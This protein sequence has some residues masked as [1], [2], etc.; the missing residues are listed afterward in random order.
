M[1]QQTQLNKIEWQEVE[2]RDI[3]TFEEKT[4]IK[5]G[6]GLDEGRYKFFTSSDLQ[7]RFI[8]KFNF[9]GEHL[10]FSTGGRAG[11]HYCNEPFSVSNDCF[12]VKV[13]GHSTKFIYYLLKSKIYLL[14][15]GFKGAGLRHL[16]KDYL[17]NI[18]IRLPFF[19]GIPSLKEQERIVSILEQAE[20]LKQKGK[21]AEELLDEYLKSVFVEI[22]VKKKFTK[23]ILNNNCDKICVS[24]VG[25]CDKYYTSS[26][27]GVPMIRTGN[28]KENYLDLTE[29][30]YVTREFHEKNKKSQL[31]PKDLLIARHGANGQAALVPNNLKEANCL[32]VVIIRINREKYNPLFL[33]FLFNSKNTL[34][35]IS[36][37]T[38]GS[39]Q[40]VINTRAIQ[41]LSL[42]RPPLPLQ[43]KFA[44]IVEQVEK[45]KEN[46]KK[47]KQNSG[48]LFDSLM[49]KA[50]R[51][52]L[53]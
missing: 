33:Q 3:F 30:K 21:E 31:H 25:P 27:K 44:S 53:E 7:S 52:E 28:L 47:T 36:G 12:T 14:E 19:N 24:Y 6:E 41:N 32:N 39:T 20:E 29:L 49:Q 45:M 4:G 34:T 9:G 35:Q 1:K 8:D 40:S 2:F 5:A 51:G 46:I 22:F 43:Q 11:L 38:G 26:E 48:E 42:I 37:K 16:S 23:E 17:K 13:N 15:R 10:I 18:R 50:F